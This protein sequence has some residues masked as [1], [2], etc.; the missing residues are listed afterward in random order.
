MFGYDRGA[1]KRDRWKRHRY[2]ETDTE[3]INIFY[4]MF[5]ISLPPQQFLSIQV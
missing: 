1:R 2:K 5:Q 4:K 3:T